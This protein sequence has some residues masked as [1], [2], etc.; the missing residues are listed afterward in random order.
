[1][2][3]GLVTAPVGV[4]AGAAT[5]Y[6]IRKAVNIEFRGL[7][8]EAIHQGI[9]LS[10]LPTIEGGDLLKVGKALYLSPDSWKAASISLA[11]F[12]IG[13]IS[14]I[15]ITSYI[16]I[17][18]SLISSPLFY[19]SIDYQIFGAVLNTPAELIGAVT[20]GVILFAVGANLTEQASKYYLKM[21]S[22]I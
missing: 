17:S 16:S 20:A 15:F 2:I 1:M 19:S 4:L 10:Y 7:R 6:A 5:L 11:K 12:P 21:N 18:I 14:L 8:D 13:I 3:A 9:E 22:A